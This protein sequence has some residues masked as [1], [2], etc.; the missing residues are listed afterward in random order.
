LIEQF[1]EKI[2]IPIGI[3]DTPEQLINAFISAEDGNFFSHIGID[4]K[5]LARAVMAPWVVL[6]S[7]STLQVSILSRDG[8]NRFQKPLRRHKLAA[9][10]KFYLDIIQEFHFY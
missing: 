2:R 10:G 8:R 7:C 4:F 9:P 3:S 6:Q 1:G 5:G